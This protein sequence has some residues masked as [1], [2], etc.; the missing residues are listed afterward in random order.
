MTD[1][2]TN[3]ADKVTQAQI[4]QGKR[5][6]D[7]IDCHNT[8][9]HNFAS[10]SDLVDQALQQEHIDSSLPFIK[11]EA[12]ALF[13]PPAKSLPDAA[14]KIQTLANFYEVNYPDIYAQK[15]DKINQAIVQLNNIAKLTTFPDMNVDWNT[16]ADNTFTN[17]K[18]GASSGCFRRHG[19]LVS[20]TPSSTT[21][22]ASASQQPAANADQTDTMDASCNLCHY[23]PA[24]QTT[25]PAA[26][27]IPHDIS[28][29]S[30]C[31]V[32]HG[33]AAAKPFPADHP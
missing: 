27:V 4:D 2:W 21:N 17:W 12:V 20:T 29:L 5:L 23:S 11:K 10:P 13:D 25:L 15:S 22:F 28:G 33:P 31:L 7:C 18:N 8:S 26:N 19:T 32:Y 16:Y 9:G 24:A 6:M 30:N 14:S 1:Q 3:P